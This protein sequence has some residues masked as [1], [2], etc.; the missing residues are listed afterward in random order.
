MFFFLLLYAYYFVIVNL[1][2]GGAIVMKIKSLLKY[3]SCIIVPIIISII[4]LLI[5]IKYKFISMI[6]PQ[7]IDILIGIIVS[8]VGILLTVLTIYLSF[9]KSE[10][11]LKRL[12]TS[13][14]NYILISNIIFGVIFYFIAILLWLFSNYSEGII[15]LF[16]CGSVNTIISGYYIAYLSHI[17]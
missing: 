6:S 2:K 8:M 13:G 14:H 9:P 4:A 3:Y 11:I 1:K 16:L 7:K 15:I 12:K 17:T 10:I 5:N